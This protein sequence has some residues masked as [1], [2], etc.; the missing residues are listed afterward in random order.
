MSSF[1]AKRI[2]LYGLVLLSCNK[3]PKPEP[4]SPP[5]I[6]EVPVATP[7][8]EPIPKVVLPCPSDMVYIE[9]A[10][11]CIDR[12]E[13]PNQ[14]G[15]KPFAAQT[16][17]QAVNYCKSVGKELCTHQQWNTACTGP[18]HKL[19]PYGNVYKRGTCNDDKTGWV[20]VPWETMGTPAW[21]KWCK[22]QYKGE[23]SGN[24]PACVSDDGVY[25]MTG[26]VA[27]WVVE[28]K[29]PHGYVVKGGYWYGVL[30]GTPT[31]G[32]VN[33]AHAPGFNSYEF[34]FRCCKEADK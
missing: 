5:P 7:E 30:Q 34:G 21:D 24:R 12:Y 13:A 33:P 27:E 31:C 26:N 15:V 20:W 16:A 4:V 22:E 8:P 19:Y 32:F 23:P 11:Y 29:N 10:G 1:V 2:F 9:R 6:V 17:F 25:D 18:Q 28:P 3:P 14:E